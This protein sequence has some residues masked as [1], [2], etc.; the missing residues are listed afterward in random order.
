MTSNLS[1]LFPQR[2]L[3]PVPA[4]AGKVIIVTGATGPVGRELVP[5][6]LASNATVIASSRSEQRLSKLRSRSAEILGSDLALLE[7][8]VADLRDQRA[9]CDLVDG[10]LQRHGRVDA[11]F[12]LVG[13]WSAG[14]VTGFDTQALSEMLTNQVLPIANIT[15]ASLDPLVQSAGRFISISTPAAAK[16]QADNT[17]YAS[18]KAASESWVRAMA[19]AFNGT[20]ASASFLIVSAVLTERFAAT[21]PT[22]NFTGWVVDHHLARKLAETLGA[23]YINGIGILA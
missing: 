5:L 10:V 23:H 2:N 9:A 16:P 14:G 21:N 13:G 4:A 17:L 8:V 11:V 19:D 6:L 15:T 3:A 7:T 12:H 1:F 22:K 20:E 18:V